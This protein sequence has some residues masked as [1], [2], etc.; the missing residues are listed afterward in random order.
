MFFLFFENLEQ[1]LLHCRGNPRRAGYISYNTFCPHLLLLFM[2]LFF[3][4]SG[5]WSSHSPS[6]SPSLSL[7]VVVKGLKLAHVFTVD[8]I[9]LSPSERS[10][11]VFSSLC[12][13]VCLCHSLLLVS[14]SLSGLYRWASSASTHQTCT[15]DSSSTFR[16]SPTVLTTPHY[17]YSDSFYLWK[18][19]S[20][21]SIVWFSSWCR[22]MPTKCKTCYR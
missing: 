9:D 4:R 10:R 20:R 1:F 6:P 21:A 15:K 5:F 12:V 22:M 17:Y 13:W 16:L 8:R 7:L 11:R 19:R 2:P 14:Q 3:Y 18:N